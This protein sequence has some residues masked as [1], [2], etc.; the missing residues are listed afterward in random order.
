MSPLQGLRSCNRLNIV[1]LKPY[2]AECRPLGAWQL[3]PPTR[4]TN[5]MHVCA[6]LLH[7]GVGWRVRVRKP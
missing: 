2:A 3:I 7:K 1:G 4:E 5:E 6:T